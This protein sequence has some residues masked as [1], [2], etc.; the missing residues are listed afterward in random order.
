MPDNATNARTTPYVCPACSRGLDAGEAQ[1]GADWLMLLCPG[2]G[3]S[4]RWRGSRIGIGMRVFALVLVTADWI[5]MV[6]DPGWRN[7]AF[8]QF[9]AVAGLGFAVWAIV[10]LVRMM[11]T[12]ARWRRSL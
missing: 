10:G 9:L 12:A 5:L 2:C 1:K 7:D 11:G 3:A 8:R 4:Y 6:V